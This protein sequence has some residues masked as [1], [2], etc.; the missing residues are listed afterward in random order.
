M[1]PSARRSSC[2]SCLRYVLNKP[3]R[4]ERHFLHRNRH[5]ATGPASPRHDATSRVQKKRRSE[6]RRIRSACRRPN[7]APAA[8]AGAHPNVVG[9]IACGAL[10]AAIGTGLILFCRFRPSAAGHFLYSHYL[11]P[12]LKQLKIAELA[13]ARRSPVSSAASV[14]AVIEFKA[15]LRPVPRC[16]NGRMPHA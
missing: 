13:G 9:G 6:R 14:S 10:A 5:V 11:L 8:A 16:P 7:L 12:S 3:L 2:S 1:L 4:N 15:H